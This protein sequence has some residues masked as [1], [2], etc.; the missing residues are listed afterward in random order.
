MSEETRRRALAASVAPGADIDMPY[1][2]AR[3]AAI[4]ARQGRYSNCADH[5]GDI[6]WLVKTVERLRDEVFTLHIYESFGQDHGHQCC[7]A[8][9]ARL[10]RALETQE[11]PASSEEHGGG[12][13]PADRTAGP[14]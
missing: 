6:D 1:E 7:I 10:T 12:S 9:I 11:A 5:P 4:E 8:E 13:E 3:L 2:E 14:T